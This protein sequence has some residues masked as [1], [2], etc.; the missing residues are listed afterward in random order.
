MPYHA[1]P[2]D[3]PVAEST[4]SKSTDLLRKISSTEGEISNE[5]SPVVGCGA[6]VVHPARMTVT[7]RGSITVFMW[8]LCR[9]RFAS[10]P[11]HHPARPA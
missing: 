7:R 2:T 3:S 5:N 8:E 6:S 1:P 9:S 11:A 4:N 10:V